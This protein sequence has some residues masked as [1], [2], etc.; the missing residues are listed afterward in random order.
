MVDPRIAKCLSAKRESRSVEFKIQ[1]LLSDPK[2][3]IEVLKDIVAIANSGGG[4]LAIG[5]DN[6]GEAAG[7][8]VS[9]VLNYDQAKYCD[10]IHKYTL[11]NFADFEV[12]EATKS[13]MTVAIFLINPPDYPLVFEKVGTYAVEGKQHT[14]FSQGT[15][16]FRHGAKTELGTY[17]DIRK[18][19]QT[20]MREMERQFVKGLRKVSEAPRGSQIEV[21]PLTSASG[22][23]LS[24]VP[25]RL[26]TDAGAQDAVAIDRHLIC[27]YRQKEVLQKL[28]ERFPDGSAPLR[29]D[30]QIINKVYDVGSKGKFCWKPQYSSPQYS[31]QYIDWIVEKMQEDAEFLT[32]AHQSFRDMTQLPIKQ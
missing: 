3:L 10:L 32:K 5:I 7:T 15:I 16:Y 4:T 2:Q 30:I 31:D 8:D 20:R 29:R 14:A 18:F 26:T 19:M 13:G 21:V 17:D 1:F 25:F 28:K 12:I 6:T 24:A 9:E 23:D 27:P 11:Q 22:S